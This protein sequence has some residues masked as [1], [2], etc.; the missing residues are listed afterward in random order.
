MENTIELLFSGVPTNFQKLDAL[1]EF[2]G[3]QSLAWTRK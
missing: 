1:E 3:N 2:D